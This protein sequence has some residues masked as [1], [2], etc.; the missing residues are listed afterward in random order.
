MSEFSLALDTPELLL[1]ILEYLAA[2]LLLSIKSAV[3]RQQTDKKQLLLL[4]GHGSDTL[5]L[6]TITSHRS[7]LRMME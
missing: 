6:E 2:K 1:F 4:V 5:P 7:H 3:F